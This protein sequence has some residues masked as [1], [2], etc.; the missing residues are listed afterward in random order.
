MNVSS[1]DIIR[2]VIDYREGKLDKVGEDALNDWMNESE[3][4][5]INLDDFVGYIND[6][7]SYSKL[8]AINEKR[9]WEK[10]SGSLGRSKSKKQ[11]EIIRLTM[12]TY[13]DV[14][15]MKYAANLFVNQV[16]DRG[17]IEEHPSALDQAY[18]LGGQLAGTDKPP[19]RP[20]DIELA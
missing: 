16:D 5:R 19:E 15:D 12:K 1:K 3:Q 6:V 18:R 7:H 10:I 17:Q 8:N 14:L 9:V 11:F 20:I 4:G 2:R 13:F